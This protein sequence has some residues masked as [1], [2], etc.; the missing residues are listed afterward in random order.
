MAFRN[1]FR[2]DGI[3]HML[4]EREE[5]ETIRDILAATADL[6]RRFRVR[7]A[8]L[9][10]KLLER[11]RA[12]DSVQVFSLKVLDDGELELGEIAVALTNDDRYLLQSC[13]PARA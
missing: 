4:W 12:I 1:F 5:S 7:D 3:L 9:L 11:F 2:D 6:R 8:E 10:D 13:E